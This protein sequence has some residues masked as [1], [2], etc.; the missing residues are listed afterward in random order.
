MHDLSLRFNSSTINLNIQPKDFIKFVRNLKDYMRCELEEIHDASVDFP[1]GR[2]SLPKDGGDVY[3]KFVHYSSFKCAKE[4]WEE[5]KNRIDWDNIF[6]LLEGPSFTPELLDMCAEVEYPLSVMGPENPEIEATYPFYHGFKW[7][8]NWRSGK[9]LD[10]K[11][12]FSLK[13]YLD[14]FDYISFLNGNKS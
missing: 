11:H 14:D 9:S 12:I 8:N 2:L 5:R 4:K 6:V 7:Y 10:Y 13:R 1:V 3:I